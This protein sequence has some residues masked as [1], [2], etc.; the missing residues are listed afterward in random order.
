MIDF[1]KKNHASARAELTLS[2]Y[3]NCSLDVST[4]AVAAVQTI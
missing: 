1:R 2:A 3:F 4:A